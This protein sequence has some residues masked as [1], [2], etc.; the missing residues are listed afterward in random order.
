MTTPGNT[1]WELNRDTLIAAAYR[2]IGIPGEDNTLSTT[3]VTDG[4]EG[5]VYMDSGTHKLMCH[6][7]M[8]WNAL[9]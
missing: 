4:A 9:F 3:Q 1:S 5:D 2:K 6:N 7:G 8:T